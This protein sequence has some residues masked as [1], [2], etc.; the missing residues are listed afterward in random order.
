MSIPDDVDPDALISRLA[1][2][3]APAD[4][5]AFRR[6]A[7]HALE[8]LPCAGEGLVYRIVSGLWRGYFHPPDDRRTGWDIS[9]ELGHLCDSRLVN[10]SPI[11]ADDPRTGGRDRR[12]LKQLVG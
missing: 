2:G 8:Q 1:G 6:A 5:A 4:R 3:L 9:Q 10:R 12:R 11:G 7:E